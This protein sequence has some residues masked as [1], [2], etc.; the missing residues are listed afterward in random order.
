M[1]DLLRVETF[2][3][4]GSDQVMFTEV[5]A[6][7]HRASYWLPFWRALW[8]CWKLILRGIEVEDRS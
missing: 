2:M 1:T 6:N 8:N 3:R 4:E 5:Y 7:G